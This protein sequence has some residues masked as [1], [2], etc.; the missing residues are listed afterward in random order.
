MNIAFIINLK[1]RT[2]TKYNLVIDVHSFPCFSLFIR[3]KVQ[4]S[5][6][7]R[8][9]S[10]SAHNSSYNMFLFNIVGFFTFMMYVPNVGVR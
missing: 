6:G 8:D 7:L 9:F 2:K 5:L 3:L 1:I 10:A 4:H